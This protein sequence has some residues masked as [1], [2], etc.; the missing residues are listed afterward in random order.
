VL[1]LPVAKQV[2]LLEGVHD[3]LRHHHGAVTDG[4]H[5]RNIIKYG[6]SVI[7][8]EKVITRTENVSSAWKKYNKAPSVRIV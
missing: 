5:G 7:S 4:L 8:M 6:T 2:E 1:A 3:V